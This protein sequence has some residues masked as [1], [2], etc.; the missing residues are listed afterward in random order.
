MS[1]NER[2]CGY[3]NYWW[4]ISNFL[5]TSIK[6]YISNINFHLRIIKRTPVIIKMTWKINYNAFLQMDDSKHCQDM[7]LVF[8]FLFF[9]GRK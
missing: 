3:Q 9:K 8:L 7:I 4:D 5:A 2:Y 6:I 1:R